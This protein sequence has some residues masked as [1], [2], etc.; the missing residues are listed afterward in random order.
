MFEQIRDI[1]AEQLNVNPETLTLETNLMKDLN[2]DSLDAVEIVL[3]IEDRFGVEIP[4]ED[5]ENLQVIQDFIN[6]I[7]RNDK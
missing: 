1:I 7:E 5:I 3:A 4:D 6:A 2:I